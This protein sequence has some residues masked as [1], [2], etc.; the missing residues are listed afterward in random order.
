M[1]DVAEFVAG[2]RKWKTPAEAIAQMELVAVK[3]HEL[4][5][6]L[7]EEPE[8]AARTEA[9]EQQSGS[10]TA[11]GT[12]SSSTT[13]TGSSTSTESDASTGAALINQLHALSDLREH[14]KLGTSAGCRVGDKSPLSDCEGIATGGSAGNV[15]SGLKTDYVILSCTELPLLLAAEDRATLEALGLCVIDPNYMLAKAL[16]AFG[17][18]I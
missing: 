5:R 4:K 8:D 18:Y 1:G 14:N 12:S 2:F 9:P 10:T 13:T 17:R 6:K 7:A 3:M 11:A 15:Q 16:L